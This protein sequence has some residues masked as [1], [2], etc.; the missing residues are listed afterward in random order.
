MRQHALLLEL[1]RVGK[2]PVEAV[3][4]RA[5]RGSELLGDLLAEIGPHQVELRQVAPLRL[6]RLGDRD[7]GLRATLDRG[8]RTAGVERQRG[9]HRRAKRRIARLEAQRVGD[10]RQQP[11]QRRADALRHLADDFLKARR[12][13][14]GQAGEKVGGRSGQ[15]ALAPRQVDRKRLLIFDKARRGGDN[16]PP[17]CLQRVCRGLCRPH[18]VI[19]STERARALAQRLRCRLEAHRHRR[20]D[21]LRRSGQRKK[22]THACRTKGK[23]MGH[24]AAMPRL[25]SP[26][27]V[28]A[29]RG[30]RPQYGLPLRPR[31]LVPDVHRSNLM[32]AN[33]KP[34]KVTPVRAS[35]RST[36]RTRHRRA[37]RGIGNPPDIR[38]PR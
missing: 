7:P 35:G 34:A 6:R 14:P 19:R 21:I 17:Q 10:C 20:R 23:Q 33:G 28:E 37:A 13:L 26:A 5:R 4:R 25:R 9:G 15:V 8:D 18:L 11:G 1:A 22:K 31:T 38:R 3:A 30:V 29:R 16:G 32:V 27:Q 36:A 24:V 12:E 2:V